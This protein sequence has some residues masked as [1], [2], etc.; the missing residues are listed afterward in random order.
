MYSIGFQSLEKEKYM[1]GVQLLSDWRCFQIATYG[2]GAQIKGEGTMSLNVGSRHWSLVLMRWV[3]FNK[4][5]VR[6]ELQ[7]RSSKNL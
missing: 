6:K 4:V 3:K 1:K 2:S 7:R 5:V